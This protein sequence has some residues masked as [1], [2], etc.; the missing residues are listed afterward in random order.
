M[1]FPTSNSRFPAV[2]IDLVEPSRLKQRLT[3]TPSLKEQLFHSGEVLYCE[4]QSDPSQHLAARFAAKEAVIKA[5]GIDGFDPLDVEIVGG[6]ESCDVRLHREVR[7]RA[8][9]L[10]VQVT[11]S[12]TH[13]PSL[14]AAI[15]IARKADAVG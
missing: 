3:D 11:I 7:R 6:G 4:S 9:E 15:A 14:A 2:G 13:L 10:A 8:D 12:M 1:D 5:L